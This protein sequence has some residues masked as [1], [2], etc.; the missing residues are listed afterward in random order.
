MKSKMNYIIDKIKSFSKKDKNKS[1]KE[2][3]TLKSKLIMM[4]VL[5]SIIPSIIIAMFVYS[6][7]K[8]SIEDQVSEMT[9]EMGFLLT[10]NFDKIILD[11]ED[12]TR[13]PTTNSDLMSDLTQ[14]FEN[15]PQSTIDR[16]QRN[17]RDYFSLL[18]LDN[19][20]IRTM[21]F[22]K[23]DGNIFGRPDS[24]FDS[25]L[26]F[27]TELE[28]KVK[29]K[30]GEVL[31]VSGFQDDN[32]IYVLRSLKNIYNRDVGVLILQ[33]KPEIFAGLFNA[34]DGSEDQGIYVIDVEDRVV[35]SNK[36][37]MIGSNYV[38]ENTESND[39][40][41]YVSEIANDW[42][43]LISTPYSYL[44]K[45]INGIIK[46]VY[47]IVI[48]FIILAIIAGVLFT[49][50]ITKP[51]NNLIQSMKKAEQGD[52]TVTADYI[53]DTEIGQLGYSFNYM[54]KNM[55]DI[56]NENKIITNYALESSDNLK[57]ISNESAITSEHIAKTVEGVSDGAIDQVNSA[58]HTNDEMEN[59]S[60]EIMEISNSITKVT[61]ETEQNQLLSS[62]SIDDIEELINRNIE[63]GKNIRQVNE[64]I[65]KLSQN[66][67]EIGGIIEIIE[68]ISDQT[69]L[70]SLNATIEAARAGESGRGFAVVAGEVRKLAEKSQDSTQKVGSVIKNIT[71]KMN[72]SVELVNTTFD[73]FEKQTVSVDNTKDSFQNII[74]NTDSIIAEIAMIDGSTE[75]INKASGK[76]VK[77]IKN[78]V[79]IAEIS[80][81]T[82]EEVTAAT[83]EQAASAQELGDLS[84]NLTEII[85]KM[86][87]TV[88]KF[89]V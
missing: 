34:E 70:L 89:K 62:K 50:T 36:T 10:Y 25:S 7:S 88:N 61:S 31:W 64:T 82:T 5:C 86:E 26:Y 8:K 1:N 87:N 4:F 32:D 3:L 23:D 30:S 14:D 21:F 83:E 22:L 52:L 49:F 12:I 55:K 72:Q 81:A 58:N 67:K 73:L 38:I 35:A 13:L 9:F 16:T 78:M 44:M 28:Q 79:D 42:Q 51:I 80:S 75:K 60:I 77:A 54:I 71:N 84:V 65:M 11:M 39:E 57:N 66:I 29:E 43:L 17:A 48:L 41:I 40:L 2:S 76:V 46:Y 24:N 53:N 15:E 20:N 69:N 19:S 37:D 59:L 18:T 56:I 63:V 6:A 68:S 33:V 85:L 27:D 74:S 47:T 45:D